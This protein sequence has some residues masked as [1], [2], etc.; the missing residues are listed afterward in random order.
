[1]LLGPALLSDQ[2]SKVGRIFDLLTAV[3]ASSV[4]RDD[5]AA[6]G[7]AHGV[8]VGE[9][10]ERAL[11]SVVRHRVVVEIEARVGVFPISTSTR[12]MRKSPP[13][14]INT[15]PSSWRTRK[16]M[17]IAA[18]GACRPWRSRANPSSGRTVSM[19]CYGA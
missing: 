10:D 13:I 17:L 11:R 8:E 7:D 5:R 6:V 18:I 3:P 9:H 2:A 12:S 14:P 15:K 1:M 4:R 16:L 19:F